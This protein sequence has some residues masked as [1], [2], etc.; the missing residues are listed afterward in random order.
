M[1]Y[2]KILSGKKVTCVKAIRDDVEN[3]G[4]QFFDEEVVVD[5][6]IITSRTPKD[7]AAWSRAMVNFLEE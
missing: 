5:G 4:A 6:N 7:L 1:V 2:A 3:A